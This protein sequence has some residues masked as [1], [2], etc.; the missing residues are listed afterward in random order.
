MTMEIDGEILNTNP[1]KMKLINKINNWKVMKSA[2]T[3]DPAKKLFD[4]ETNYDT[5][6]LIFL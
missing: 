4:L 2:I 5:G 1:L 3:I 6:M